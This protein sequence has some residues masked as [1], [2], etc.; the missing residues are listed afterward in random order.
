[1]SFV[2]EEKLKFPPISMRVTIDEAAFLG[3]R[4]RRASL[5]PARDLHA[6]KI[7]N[8]MGYLLYMLVYGDEYSTTTQCVYSQPAKRRSAP[9]K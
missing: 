6:Q 5:T 7:R 8:M 1:M 2:I 3:V 9:P 4:G